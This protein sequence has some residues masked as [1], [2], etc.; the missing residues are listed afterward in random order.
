[1]KRRMLLAG[2]VAALG[3]TGSASAGTVEQERQ[4]R[5]A[6]E[7]RIEERLEMAREEE[8]FPRAPDRY[9]A[10]GAGSL[11]VESAETVAAQPG[12]ELVFAVVLDQA[13]ERGTLRLTLPEV[14]TQTAVSGLRFAEPPR[15]QPGAPAGTT[16]TRDGRTVTLSVRDADVGD[17]AAIVVRDIGIPAGEYELPY[18]W[19]GG[20]TGSATV[21]LYAPARE[22]EGSRNPFWR[23]NPN[24]GF[25]TN[26][27]EAGDQCTFVDC[28]ATQGGKEEQS[29]TYIGVSPNDSDRILVQSNNID[30]GTEG[31]FLSIDGG[32]TFK[33]MKIPNDF[34]APGET[35][36]EKG[37]YCCDPMSAED[38]LGNIWFG[39]LTSA[40]GA[41]NPSRIVVNRIAAGTTDFQTRT[42][43]LPLPDDGG[44]ADDAGQQDKNLMTIDNSP[45]SPTYGRLYVVWNDTGGGNAI[46][47][48]HCDT[49][50]GGISRPEVCDEADNWTVPF[51][52]APRGSLIYA[53]AAV[54]PEGIVYVT[55]WDFSSTNA[56]RGRFCDARTAD[57]GKVE[58]FSEIK[59]IALLNNDLSGVN[60][61]AGQ[62]LPFACPIPA[63]PG[64]RPGPSPGVD[65]DI[66]N[67][68]NRGRVYVVWGDLRPG[69]GV[70]RCEEAGPAGSPPGPD[71]LSWD[72]FIASST[73]GTLPGRRASSY[74]IATRLYTE[75]GA[76]EADDKGTTGAANSDEWFPWLVVDPSTGQA[77][78]DFYSTR[79]DA[80]RRRVHFYT[81]SV[82]PQEGAPG[83]HALGQLTRSS[84]QDSDYSAGTTG[85]CV[86]GNDYGDY[87]GLDAA[88]GFVFPVWTRRAGVGDDG[89]AYTVVPLNNPQLEL[90]EA[91]AGEGAG[92]DQDG[93]VEPGEPVRLFVRVRN[94]SD[95]T[96]TNVAGT[97]AS[98][99][100]KA[101]VTQPRSAYPD[102]LRSGG[103]GENTT[104]FEAA[105]DT[106][107]ACR[108]DAP[109]PIDFRVDL[110]TDQGPESVAFTIPVCGRATAP[111]VTPPATT[112]APPPAAPAPGPVACAAA[113]GFRQAAVSPSGRRVGLSFT[114]RAGAGPVTVDVFQ[115]S[116][117]RR[118]IGERLVARFTGK[119]RSFTWNGRANRKGRRVSDGYYFVRFRTRS[120]TGAD[121]R[122]LVL[123]RVRGR[124]SR[125]RAHERREGCA[126]IGTFKLT[127]P[128]FGG[129]SNRELGIAY[130]LRRNAEAEVE[131]LRG[132]EVV[133]R[134]R[135]RSVTAGTLVRLRFDSEGLPR[136]DYRVRLV[137]RGAGPRP[138][139]ATLTSRRL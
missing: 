136:G 27:T 104:A 37:A 53:D 4:A 17:R 114:R 78:A 66:S 111:G 98:L 23:I 103:K 115:Q 137:L 91:R 126:A 59:D 26:A 139:T 29:E 133:K 58:G 7:E 46:V 123:R 49:R 77:W 120:A 73:A 85:C 30:D 34:D 45:T 32:R 119:T 125:R 2:L 95:V 52:V 132:T 86:F 99:T 128:V 62:P 96:V 92:A 70:R 74:D 89:D 11:V 41:G 76:G 100:P 14:W 118:V 108:P 55:W 5:A 51:I 68:P 79:H 24:T 1:M 21:R 39:G 43:A 50:P 105:L 94:P 28:Q 16:L 60:D 42:V 124:F 9:H 131:V 110:A 48:S 38:N 102:V 87:T 138:V 129:P 36:V 106:N 3:A 44:A 31:A 15:L 127:R 101:T 122:R 113:A 69:S 112:P 20:E 61:N 84:V 88:E 18:A 63:Q 135:R 64:G 40:N 72:S 12:Q 109:A 35:G 47:I 117:G 75:E 19:A 81:R 25:E 83:G 67:G 65:T 71:V 57:C 90:D 22:G 130:R 8:G 13:V 134:F 121:V 33:R 93:F 56:I 6:A 80:T 107:I 116:V 54:G 10:L 82:T 97:L